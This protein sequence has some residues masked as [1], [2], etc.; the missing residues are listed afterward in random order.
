MGNKWNQSIV[1]KKGLKIRENA[2]HLGGSVGEASDFGSSHDLTVCEL[3]PPMLG[4]V[5]TAQSLGPAFDS[6]GPS[7]S[8]PPLFVLCLS[9]ITQ[10]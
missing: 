6:V 9:K 4:S 8:A 1:L 3:E 2:E 5:L 10:F 7:L